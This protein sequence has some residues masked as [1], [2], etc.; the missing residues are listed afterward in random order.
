MSQQRPNLARLR[1]PV[2]A[3]WPVAMALGLNACA[4]PPELAPGA[5]AISGE[6]SAPWQAQVSA[7]SDAARRLSE[8]EGEIVVA[9][10]VAAHEKRRP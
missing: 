4:S 9:N 5:I 1:L 7:R 3:F 10:A 2:Q 8:G 6:R